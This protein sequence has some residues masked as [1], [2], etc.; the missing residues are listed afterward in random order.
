M[1]F[2]YPDLMIGKFKLGDIIS[3]SRTYPGDFYTFVEKDSDEYKIL[4]EGIAKLTDEF[5]LL[6]D[7]LKSLEE[8]RANGGL[9][10]TEWS[11]KRAVTEKITRIKNQLSMK[12]NRRSWIEFIM[13]HPEYKDD[14]AKNLWESQRLTCKIIKSGS[15]YDKTELQVLWSNIAEI[16]EEQ[17]LTFHCTLPSEMIYRHP[18]E[19][20]LPEDDAAPV[21]AYK[22]FRDK[23]P[24]KELYG[25]GQFHTWSHNPVLSMGVGVNS[26]KCLYPNEM[27]CDDDDLKLYCS[28][29]FNKWTFVYKVQGKLIDYIVRLARNFN[30]QCASDYRENGFF[31]IALQ[32]DNI[33]KNV[34]GDLEATVPQNIVWSQGNSNTKAYNFAYFPFSGL[35][36]DDLENLRSGQLLSSTNSNISQIICFRKRIDRVNDDTYRGIPAKRYI[37]TVDK[38]VIHGPNPG[39][40]IERYGGDGW[41]RDENDKGVYE[42]RQHYTFVRRGVQTFILNQFNSELRSDWMQTRAQM[43]NIVTTKLFNKH[44][45]N[46]TG[47]IIEHA[48]YKLNDEPSDYEDIPKTTWHGTYFV[49]HEPRKVVIILPTDNGVKKIFKTIYRASEYIHRWMRD[50]KERLLNNLLMMQIFT[51]RTTESLAP[52][53][54]EEGLERKFFKYISELETAAYE[55]Y[56]N[57]AYFTHD[58]K[59]KIVDEFLK[60]LTHNNIE[61]EDWVQQIDGD[62]KIMKA[63]WNQRLNQDGTYWWPNEGKIMI[64][65]IKGIIRRRPIDL[66]TSTKSGEDALTTY[67]F[68]TITYTKNLK[69]KKE[70]VILDYNKPSCADVDINGD[71]IVLNFIK[72]LD[73]RQYGLSLTDRMRGD[74][75]YTFTMGKTFVINENYDDFEKSLGVA[76]K[77]LTLLENI[78]TW[79]KKI[80]GIKT[81]FLFFDDIAYTLCQ[82]AGIGIKE[83]LLRQHFIA[84]LNHTK[85]MNFTYRPEK[86]AVGIEYKKNDVVYWY[87]KK[88]GKHCILKARADFTLELGKQCD[89]RRYEDGEVIEPRDIFPILSGTT[90]SI[91][92][93]TKKTGLEFMRSKM[94]LSMDIHSSA[95]I[96]D[97][98]YHVITKKF[99]EEL[100][101][102]SE[103]IE[104][105]QDLQKYVYA[106]DLCFTDDELNKAYI[107]QKNT[108][109]TTGGISIPSEKLEDYSANLQTRILMTN[110]NVSLLATTLEDFLRKKGFWALKE[111]DNPDPNFYKFTVSI[112]FEPKTSRQNAP[113]SI[114]AKLSGG[115]YKSPI[116]QIPMV[117]DSQM[118]NMTGITLIE[119]KEAVNKEKRRERRIFIQ[120]WANYKNILPPPANVNDVRYKDPDSYA[121]PVVPYLPDWGALENIDINCGGTDDGHIAIRKNREEII[122]ELFI[123]IKKVFDFEHDVIYGDVTMQNNQQLRDWLSAEWKNFKTKQNPKA[124]DL[125]HPLIM[126]PAFLPFPSAPVINNNVAFKKFWYDISLDNA[127]E[128]IRKE[129]YGKVGAALEMLYKSR[130]FRIINLM[131]DMFSNGIPMEDGTRRILDTMDKY[132]IIQKYQSM[133]IQQ[134]ELKA[135]EVLHQGITWYVGKNDYVQLSFHEKKEKRKRTSNIL[136]YDWNIVVEAQEN[137]FIKQDNGNS[138]ELIGFGN[139]F[140]PEWWMLNSHFF[141]DLMPQWFSLVGSRCFPNPGYVQQ[142]VQQT[143]IINVLTKILNLKTNILTVSVKEKVKQNIMPDEKIIAKCGLQTVVQIL[144][145]VYQHAFSS[146][147]Q[148]E[149]EGKNKS[150]KL[151]LRG[152]WL[153]NKKCLLFSKVEMFIQG[154]NIILY[155]NGK[156]NTQILYQSGLKEANDAKTLF[157]RYPVHFIFYSKERVINDFQK[158]IGADTVI[159]SR[160]M[161]ADNEGYYVGPGLRVSDYIT[162]ENMYEQTS[163]ISSEMANLMENVHFLNKGREIDRGGILKELKEA[164]ICGTDGKQLLD[165]N[166]NPK[167]TA[168]AID[169]V[170]EYKYFGLMDKIEHLTCELA[171]LANSQRENTIQGLGLHV[172][173]NKYTPD[174]IDE[175]LG[176]ED[177]TCVICKKL[178]ATVYMPNCRGQEK[179]VAHV[180]CLYNQCI[181]DT[182]L[183]NKS[184]KYFMINLN[185]TMMQVTKE[186]N[187][188]GQISDPEIEP[189]NLTIREFLIARQAYFKDGRNAQRVETTVYTTIPLHHEQ[190]VPI[191]IENSGPTG[192]KYFLKEEKTNAIGYANK[193]HYEKDPKWQHLEAF[194]CREIL[195]GEVLQ[196]GT[197]GSEAKD[198]DGKYHSILHTWTEASKC[199][200]CTTQIGGH[201]WVSTPSDI[202]EGEMYTIMYAGRQVVPYDRNKTAHFGIMSPVMS[203]DFNFDKYGY[204]TLLYH[205]QPFGRAEVIAPSEDE[206]NNFGMGSLELYTGLDNYI[207]IVSQEEPQYNVP[208]QLKSQKKIK[209]HNE[210]TGGE[211]RLKQ[212]TS[213]EDLGKIE[214]K[215]MIGG[216]VKTEIEHYWK[217][218]GNGRLCAYELE[219]KH[220]E[221]ENE[222][223]ELDFMGEITPQKKKN[224]I[225][226][227]EAAYDKVYG[228]Q[229]QNVADALKEQ[230]AT[231][232]ALLEKYGNVG[233]YQQIERKWKC[234]FTPIGCRL[235]NITK[236]DEDK[237]EITMPWLPILPPDINLNDFKTIIEENTSFP[238]ENKFIS[239]RIPSDWDRKTPIRKSNDY[240]CWP[241]YVSVDKLK[242]MGAKPGST[243]L[244]EMYEDVEADT[245]EEKLTKQHVLSQLS[246]VILYKIEY[247]GKRTGSGFP[248]L[249][250]SVEDD[251]D[252][253]ERRLGEPIAKILYNMGVDKFKEFT[254]PLPVD[255]KLYPNISVMEMFMIRYKNKKQLINSKRFKILFEFVEGGEDDDGEDNHK[256]IPVNKAPMV[257]DCPYDVEIGDIKKYIRAAD[258]FKT[259]SC[260]LH[261]KLNGAAVFPDGRPIFD[262][263]AIYD[264]DSFFSDFYKDK[265]L[266]IETFRENKVLCMRDFEVDE[267]V[268]PHTE[269]TTWTD[270]FYTEDRQLLDDEDTEWTEGDFLSEIEDTSDGDKL[271]IINPWYISQYMDQSQKTIKSSFESGSASKYLKI[272]IPIPKATKYERE[273][274]EPK[275]AK[276]VFRCKKYM[277]EIE[278]E[279]GFTTE[280]IMANVQYIDRYTDGQIDTKRRNRMPIPGIFFLDV[281]WRKE[282]LFI[283]MRKYFNTLNYAYTNAEGVIEFTSERFGAASYTTFARSE[284]KKELLEWMDEQGFDLVAVKARLNKEGENIDKV[285]YA[286]ISTQNRSFRLP[287]G[288]ITDDQQKILFPRMEILNADLDWGPLDPNMIMQRGINIELAEST[289]KQRRDVAT[290]LQSRGKVDVINHRALEIRNGQA[291]GRND[292]SNII[293]PGFQT[294]TD[295]LVSRGQNKFQSS[296]IIEEMECATNT[297]ESGN[298]SDKL[299]N[300]EEYEEF[301]KSD[302]TIDLTVYRNLAF[303]KAEASEWEKTGADDFATFSRLA[304]K[305]TPGLSRPIQFQFVDCSDPERKL[306]MRNPYKLTGSAIHEYFLPDFLPGNPGSTFGFNDFQWS[307]IFPS[308]INVFIAEI[309]YSRKDIGLVSSLD[310]PI[311]IVEEYKDG[312]WYETTKSSAELIQEINKQIK[313]VGTTMI[314]GNADEYRWAHLPNGWN[315]QVNDE[316]QVL[317]EFHHFN[318]DTEGL[319]SDTG[320]TP[321]LKTADSVYMDNT[322]LPAVLNE[323]AEEY[324]DESTNFLP[325]ASLWCYREAKKHEGQMGRNELDRN[326]QLSYLSAKQWTNDEDKQ[327]I[328]ISS[329]LG[330]DPKTLTR[331]ISLNGEGY[332]IQEALFGVEGTMDANNNLYTGSEWVPRFNI[333]ITFKKNT[334]RL[335]K[336][337]FK[338]KQN[339]YKGIIRDDGT[340][341]IYSDYKPEIG[342]LVL[343]DNHTDDDGNDIYGIVSDCT[344]LVTIFYFTERDKKYIWAKNGQDSFSKAFDLKA[345]TANVFNPITSKF[346]YNPSDCFLIRRGFQYPDRDMEGGYLGDNT[347][348]KIRIGDMVGDVVKGYQEEG[349]KQPKR[350]KVV[351]TNPML[352][353][354]D[355]SVSPSRPLNPEA[356]MVIRQNGE[357][358][359]IGNNF[360]TLNRSNLVKLTPTFKEI[361]SSDSS[362]SDSDYE[363]SSSDDSEESLSDLLNNLKLTF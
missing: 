107:Q 163:L 289:E 218:Q 95:T 300:K 3:V 258:W 213:T 257:I 104:T 360:I 310:R 244:V 308:L 124:M 343:V 236:L 142:T 133:F 28:H 147:T 146:K 268:F 170:D 119:N 287:T 16:Q 171:T 102:I 280:I 125:G 186:L 154:K 293:S 45:L 267:R 169:E 141:T 264:D 191:D 340:K 130:A 164:P 345:L 326:R 10:D 96:G 18:T 168:V 88:K 38:S 65:L 44:G 143:G 126:A 206:E 89:Y 91:L 307:R 5:T 226:W 250:D 306:N 78:T 181:R 342:D 346:K 50:Q 358:E 139:N 225:K 304:D 238:I 270:L 64:D 228:G 253:L 335:K 177:T 197:Y 211:R 282:E 320:E 210:P 127:M 173:G 121:V 30:G 103:D 118:K 100:E 98:L 159:R 167:W 35:Q 312:K 116:K 351:M 297:F 294:P 59:K 56:V 281:E 239:V 58:H 275:Y 283:W 21:T 246:T 108:A 315:F 217:Q 277:S 166:G 357:G 110:L 29:F 196:D 234:R 172:A 128:E 222:I 20:N 235:K 60:G 174:E 83:K 215:S 243:I 344:N 208:K 272:K 109:L 82:T 331:G 252:T 248:V 155:E 120:A 39:I 232:D 62:D 274:N 324:G 135:G 37:F 138:S 269:G 290:A 188:Y 73:Y 111:R 55:D 26:N 341:Y 66:F 33:Q 49:E 285:I 81:D 339:L 40:T 157:A 349:F 47:T 93:I 292:N 271:E 8:K 249:Y 288:D 242:R 132:L 266:I 330:I 363:K 352:P 316:H 105:L 85:D 184:S 214:I 72:R 278:K 13:N 353:E 70:D 336:N 333:G 327:N 51:K 183:K 67:S 187:D 149:L 180:T 286:D 354:T 322:D 25:E 198:N 42:P 36:A 185:S 359:I 309:V 114:E 179:H 216:D 223:I 14:N 230:Q 6:D 224:L 74:K 32:R 329:Y 259:K 86:F 123:R 162:K 63:A 296:H 12:V 237:N 46:N 362:S 317:K 153:K 160:G 201:L 356:V 129:N 158:E 273:T 90:W 150:V 151:N 117:F 182:G 276:T 137:T 207:Q 34:R 156:H 202:Y 313:Y 19:I 23:R 229:Q 176:F 338:K 99:I 299:F 53:I 52:G 348:T 92:E 302:S 318:Q 192:T 263:E 319:K 9:T 15:Y 194:H 240:L 255:I 22:V 112:L 199:P 279:T 7:Q 77:N 69:T 323:N 24:V 241:E 334:I 152:H 97:L 17:K 27:V 134:D 332:N 75:L 68:E 175:I 31:T 325:R 165:D 251:K 190:A 256:I 43:K 122:L 254:L 113:I 291:A 212:R 200:A 161:L 219:I 80:K 301:L 193:E 350:F 195:S 178:G 321:S 328:Y 314:R 101:E 355:F 284:D 2:V 347:D 337:T 203:L 148:L 61:I 261:R 145:T 298:I 262:S 260:W 231:R 220:G 1:Q 115:V 136:R 11:E 265:A 247:M 140:Q 144:C 295:V 87:D 4:K 205:M 76:E 305:R 84:F 221:D 54:C 94:L 233:A 57:Y 303:T 227:I 79:S 41:L 209:R 48:E 131:N 361:F 106:I 311:Y 189:S 71:L 204:E 245:D